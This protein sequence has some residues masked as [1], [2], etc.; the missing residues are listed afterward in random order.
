MENNCHRNMKEFNKK[1]CC[2]CGVCM[3]ICPVG[4]ISMQNDEEGF[5]Y[6]VVKDELCINCGKCVIHC[7]TKNDKF[8]HWSN[9]DEAYY[10]YNKD[11]DVLKTSA[12]GGVGVA[13][14]RAFA[15]NGGYVTGVSYTRDYKSVVFELTN[16]NEDIDK[17]KGSKYVKADVSQI[18]PRIK[19]KLDSSFLVLVVALPCEIAAVKKYLDKEYDNLY[20]CELICH[21][22]TSVKV[23]E[24]C[25]CEIEARY[26]SKII[27]FSCRAK[28]PFWKPYYLDA[29]LM[30]GEEYSEIFAESD[31]GKAFQIMKRPSCNNCTFKYPYTYADLTIGD[32]HA[33][34]RKSP[35]YN[36]YGVSICF[37]HTLKGKRLINMLEGFEVGVA[38]IGRA[39]G[40]YALFQPVEKIVGRK[41]FVR[42]LE[43]DSLKK[44]VMLPQVKF[45][46]KKRTIKKKLRSLKNK[47]L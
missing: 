38:D 16:K 26:K 29:K 47:I 21:G 28:K 24:K 42:C 11:T 32:F 40:N 4:A 6:P 44:A 45:G 5:I 34:K 2:G 41:S 9:L 27:D 35:E 10:A 14:S 8:S 20:T 13:L 46:L 17:F 7:T 18:C 25:V 31:M 43:V 22:P 33:A 15:E 30:N 19:E 12:S 1:D 37:T 39:K 3:H 23:L 36:E